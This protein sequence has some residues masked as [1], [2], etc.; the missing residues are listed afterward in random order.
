MVWESPCLWVFVSK[1]SGTNSSI[2]ENSF[3]LDRDELVPK[4]KYS[5]HLEHDF[6]LRE[7]GFTTGGKHVLRKR[8]MRNSIST[9]MMKCMSERNLRFLQGSKL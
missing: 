6:Y 1:R 9:S 5:F 7:H 2:D 8:A 4:I 3:T